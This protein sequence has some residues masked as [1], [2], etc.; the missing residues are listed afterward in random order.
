[1]LLDAGASLNERCP[2]SK[3]RALQVAM[4]HAKADVVE[5]VLRAY[6]A[7]SPVLYTHCEEHPLDLACQRG[8]AGV[9]DAVANVLMEEGG[10]EKYVEKEKPQS[11]RKC[12]A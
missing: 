8:D 3:R 10:I 5:V 1:M 9:A 2:A 7:R 12:V 6:V 11:L 4:M